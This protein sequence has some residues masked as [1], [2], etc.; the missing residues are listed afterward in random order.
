MRVLL[1]RGTSDFVSDVWMCRDDLASFVSIVALLV[2]H[3]LLLV[4][5]LLRRIGRLCAHAA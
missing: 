4:L 1:Q 5:L 3:G 2:G